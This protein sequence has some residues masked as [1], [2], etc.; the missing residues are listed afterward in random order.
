MRNFGYD[1]TRKPMACEIE[2]VQG[3]IHRKTV[4]ELA[5]TPTADGKAPVVRHE[6]QMN[7]SHEL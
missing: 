1:G 3:L 6:N 4:R 5:S 2:E 7:G